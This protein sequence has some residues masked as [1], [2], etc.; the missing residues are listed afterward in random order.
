MKAKLFISSAVIASLL[1]TACSS[2]SKFSAE[3]FNVTPTPLNYAAGEVPA[4]INILIPSRAVKKKAVVTFTPELRWNNQTV[5]SNSAVVQGEKVEANHQIVSYKNGGHTSLRVAFPFVSGM[6]SCD[7]YMTFDEQ[8]GKKHKSLPAIKIGYGTQ[9]TAALVSRTAGTISPAVAPDDFQR[10][11]NKRQDATIKFLVAQ[12]NLRNSEL[13]SITMMDFIETLKNIKS[14]EESIVLRNIDVD[15]YAS[16]EGGFDFNKKLAE[17]RSKVSE[18]FIE[19]QLRKNSLS[20]DVDTK[21]TAEDWEGFQ[22]LV[23]QSNLAD[24]D[25]ILRVL[26]MYSDPEEREREIRNIATVYTELADAVLPELRRARLSINYEVIGKSDTEILSM[27]RTAPQDLSLEEMLYAANIL[28]E[29]DTEKIN[30]YNKIISLYPN[31]YRAYNNIACLY[32]HQNNLD[33]AQYNLRQALSLNASAAEPN[34][35]MA[36]LAMQDGDISNAEIYTAKA[37]GASNTDQLIGSIYISQGKFTQAAARLEKTPSNTA[38]LAQILAQDYSAAKKTLAEMKVYGATTNYLR[39]V[40]GARMG[41]TDEIVKGIS[42]CKAI[43]SN[44]AKRA[45]RDIEFQNYRSIV[46]SLF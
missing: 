20:T 41:D 21:Y 33:K 4:T 22:T 8:K 42:A 34:A 12:A 40:L 31:D 19:E 43:D 2:G 26:S 13:N 7:L 29:E 18:L 1:F 11:V 25:L 5:T 35:N 38:L 36:I 9:C 27:L 14:E 17:R 15:A 24:K 3:N 39:A 37:T 44:L 16:P 32:M 45:V 10:V 6:E 46:E 30:L 28:L 23:S